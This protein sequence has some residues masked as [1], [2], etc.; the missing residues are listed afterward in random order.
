MN[1]MGVYRWP[2]GSIY[3]GTVSLL[4]SDVASNKLIYNQCDVFIAIIDPVLY[5]V[6]NFIIVVSL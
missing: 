1:G 6:Y 5:G 2:D 4:K 3:E